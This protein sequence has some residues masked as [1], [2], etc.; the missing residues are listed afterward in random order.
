[1]N[2]IISYL[3]DCLTRDCLG[4]DKVGLL[5]HD[6]CVSRPTAVLKPM[7]VVD[8]VVAG[9]LNKLTNLNSSQREK[10]HQHHTLCSSY[11]NDTQQH[12]QS[13]H[14]VSAADDNT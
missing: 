3:T 1:M 11:M 2:G 6:C 4:V 12:R 5:Q 10:L 7:V 13:L 14:L 9:H 8:A